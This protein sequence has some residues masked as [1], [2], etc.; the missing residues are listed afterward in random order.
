MTVLASGPVDGARSESLAPGEVLAG[1][2]RIV[3]FLGRGAVG[4]VYEAFDQELNE[5]IAVKVLRPEIARD[6]RVLQRFKREIQLGRRVTHPNVC[7]V[8]DLVYHS[9]SPPAPD[10]PPDKVLLTME[11]LRGETLE[12]LLARQGRMSTA[13]ALPVIGH[14][15]AALTAAHANGVI[16]RDLKSGNIFL[17]PAPSGTRA[18]VTDFG[19][20]W[21][22]IE[23]DDSANLTATGEMVGSPAYMAPEQ[24]R[25]E[26]ATAATDVYALGVVIFEMVTGELPF[27]G[28]S[29]FYTALKRLQEPAPSPRIHLS[30][31]DS[32]W[33]KTILRC[34]EREPE[35]RFPSVRHVVRALGLTKAE[36]D[37]TSPLTLTRSW[38]RRRRSPG[39]AAAMAAMT[40][41]LAGLLALVLWGLW[42]AGLPP[43][44]RAPG[45]ANAKGPATAS[46]SA[47]ATPARPAVAVLGFDNLAGRPDAGY[48]G[49]SLLQMLPTELARAERLRLV[50]VE[51]VDR[52]R[53]DLGLS[54]STSLSPATL[55]RVRSYLGADLV[56]GGS[57][58]VT[59]P[60]GRTRFDLQVQ[61]TRTGET[62]ARVSESGTEEGFLTT[63]AVLGE[64]LRGELGAGGLPQAEAKALR[65]SLP[66]T[67]EAA[68]LYSDGAAE[69]RRFEP[70]RARDLLRQAVAAEPGD[71]LP[72]LTLAAA[73]SD[74][75][76]QE[77]ARAEART[78]LDL[79]APLR[80]ED[81]RAIEARW[82][83][84]SS[85]WPAAIAIY[86]E[87]WSYF[88]DNLEYALRLAA[89][90]IPGGAPK[91]A[92][93]TLAE[94]RR[95]PPP[96]GADARIDLAEAAAGGALS[97]FARQAQAALAAE[98][99]GR[100][101]GAQG[102]IAEARFQE[103]SAALARGEPDAA[104]AAFDEAA[105]I[106]E[107]QGDRG[108]LARVI[109]SRGLLLE[110]RGD[111]AGAAAAYG[112]SQA[113][114][115]AIG[116]EL[117]EGVAENSLAGLDIAQGRLEEA[118]SR[119][120]RALATFRRLERKAGVANVL[121]NLGVVAQ[122]KGDLATYEARL[123][124]ATAVYR[125]I[126]DRGGEART[127]TNRGALRFSRGDLDA[128]GQ[129]FAAA[130][131]VYQA[132]GDRSSA[133]QTIQ[134]QGAVLLRQG[135]PAEAERLFTQSLAVFRELKDKASE[136][137]NDLDLANAA[138]DTGDAQRAEQRAGEAR[139]LFR[140][141]G[142]PERESEALTLVALCRLAAG[143]PQEAQEA[144]QGA[145]PVARRTENPR[146][147]L[148]FA[149]TE[150]RVLAAT[151]HP[152]EALRSLRE[153]VRKAPEAGSFPLELE[154][155]LALGE[156]EILAGDPKAGRSRL[157]AVERDA[158]R[159]GF[160]I[161][162][163]KARKAA[164][165][166]SQPT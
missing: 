163:R 52:A 150:A 10:A 46:R 58:L 27:V 109:N 134:N 13:E 129:D 97:D 116:N 90:Q 130:L 61:D 120:E 95:L 118:R 94:A 49:T 138:L 14:V 7:R 151:G 102:W 115:H 112:R 26:E 60:G 128:A 44:V 135:L 71:P 32:A 59:A 81:R 155:R 145:A 23:A 20:A 21:S 54:R 93:A 141:A 11:L 45:V 73:W 36:E 30:D 25:G 152:Q 132:I 87:L 114:Q 117:G 104:L 101:L 92:L 79:S 51:N 88:P 100:T 140:Q 146:F 110:Q 6:E 15:V 156:V 123:T 31:L 35:K 133:A 57:Y 83:E 127:L 1:R 108:R 122:M 136:A 161:L 137:D 147:R 53:A 160:R 18:V 19:L 153:A 38:P 149:I 106:Y 85:D 16:H 40:A 63:L 64:R 154:A 113:I 3:G 56:I 166:A 142:N 5:A 107:S 43:F 24:V 84:L 2:Y 139:A 158:G 9:Q 70:A 121:N 143:R 91:D 164:A 126:G 148:L 165:T 17:V 8:F 72:H 77:R 89:A 41:G 78:A 119:F 99:K 29:A 76:Y 39:R 96:Q 66:S 48:L 124:E 125:E 69:L 12:Q 86:R 82:R 55:A 131:A 74:L 50:P 144:I 22:S 42:T 37:A 62:V 103:G 4:E 162:A 159:Q 65:A 80:H 67:L 68:R 34:L 111:F 75:G 157:A 28:K 105:R 33:E 47:V 98:R